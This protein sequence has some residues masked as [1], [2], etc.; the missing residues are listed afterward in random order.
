M[1]TAEPGR[2]VAVPSDQVAA[3]LKWNDATLTLIGTDGFRVL[4]DPAEFEG[5]EDALR[6]LE[7][8]TDPGL[9]VA[10]DSPGRAEKKPAD[11]AG[12]A[13]PAARR[14]ARWWPL[15][16]VTAAWLACLVFA[17]VYK[18]AILAFGVWLGAVCL[19][20]TLA[21]RALVRAVRAR[22]RSGPG[23]LGPLR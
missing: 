16:T 8:G 6:A 17:V 2:F 11:P 12:P 10:I 14:R 18:N 19:G 22:R 23:S 1:L 7:A 21:Q 5:A 15:W 3:L 9:I 13:R 4:L 20:T